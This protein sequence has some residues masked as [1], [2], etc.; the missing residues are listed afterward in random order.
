MSWPHPLSLM[1]ISPSPNNRF[2]RSQ[3]EARLQRSFAK[4]KGEVK[5]MWGALGAH[6][7]ACSSA[8]TDIVVAPRVLPLRPAGVA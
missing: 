1:G 6:E 3:V 2:A 7:P 5:A 4:A 8:M